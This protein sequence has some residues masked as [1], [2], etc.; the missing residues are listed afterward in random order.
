MIF[1]FSV[2]V[3][4][5]AVLDNVLHSLEDDQEGASHNKQKNLC[6]AVQ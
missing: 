1:S 5:S 4:K 3:V 2:E 6:I